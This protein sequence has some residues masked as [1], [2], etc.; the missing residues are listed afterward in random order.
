MKKMLS[1]TRVDHMHR[2]KIIL[3][4]LKPESPPGGEVYFPAGRGSGYAKGG[5]YEENIPPQVWMS[6]DCVIDGLWKG[7]PRR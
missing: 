4:R 5:A 2:R 6:D 7:L 1:I 3:R